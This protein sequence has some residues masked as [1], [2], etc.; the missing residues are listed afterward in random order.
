M[1][2]LG[3]IH[4]ITGENYNSILI[5]HFNSQLIKPCRLQFF[6]KACM[7]DFYLSNHFDE[8]KKLQ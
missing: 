5:A 6:Q 8:L 1:C 4:M 7:N 3:E 2:T